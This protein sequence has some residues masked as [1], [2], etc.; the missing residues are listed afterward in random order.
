MEYCLKIFFRL[1]GS[2]FVLKFRIHIQK[3][4]WLSGT[5]YPTDLNLL[6]H[7]HMQM[8]EQEQDKLQV[9]MD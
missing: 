1:D 6:M 8:E 7:N 3:S 9:A 5:S 2:N 4:A